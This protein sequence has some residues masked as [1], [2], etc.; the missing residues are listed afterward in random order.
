MCHTSVRFFMRFSKTEGFLFSTIDS[1]FTKDQLSQR[2]IALSEASEGAIYIRGDQLYQNSSAVLQAL[3]DCIMPFSFIKIGLII[4]ER[5]RDKLY[6]IV[7]KR[8]LWISK[9]LNLTC[10]LPDWADQ[11]RIVDVI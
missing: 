1:E 10:N 9:K 4:P 3:S 8:R 7:A 2:G 5:L 11:K 6:R